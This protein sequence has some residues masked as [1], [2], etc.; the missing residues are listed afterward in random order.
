MNSAVSP[1]RSAA[2][3]PRAGTATDEALVAAIRQG[4][5][6]AF[7]AVVHRYEAPLT[8]YARQV[9]GG[10]HHDAEEC[11][12]D[13]FVRALRSLRTGDAEIALRP[14]LHAIVRN[15]CLDQLRKPNRTTDL[16]PH[17]A[18]LADHGPG[19]VSTIARRE[20]LDEVVGGVEALPERQRRALVMHELEDRSHSHIGRVLGVSTGASKALVCRARA[21]VAQ[22]VGRRAA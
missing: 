21:G 11:V 7:T 18:V 4:S 22:A 17:E 15:R 12:Q 20:R 8:A 10:R 13:A 9:L 14:W 2:R 16:D 5:D 6:A 19:P 1:T 3:A